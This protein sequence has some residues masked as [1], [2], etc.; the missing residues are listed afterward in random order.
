MIEVSGVN[1]KQRHLRSRSCAVTGSVLGGVAEEVHQDDRSSLLPA[2]G[3]QRSK[4][5]VHRFDLL[6]ASSGLA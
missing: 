1:G 4:G 3:G 2:E 5:R 6:E